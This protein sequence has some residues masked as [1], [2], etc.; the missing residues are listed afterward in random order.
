ME[1]LFLTQYLE[2]ADQ[3]ADRIGVI[4]QGVLIAEGTSKELKASVGAGRLSVHF[5]T[6]EDLE[7]AHQILKSLTDEPVEVNEKGMLLTVPIKD[8]SDAANAISR[9]VNEEIQVSDF[10]MGQP[11]LDEVFLTLT[12]K[13]TK[14][15]EEGGI[16]HD[17]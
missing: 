14:Q 15:A 11:S 12:G 1:P 7:K 6:R 10:Q 3:L 5:H 8:H 13:T 9:L 4:D 17:E 16:K 2:E